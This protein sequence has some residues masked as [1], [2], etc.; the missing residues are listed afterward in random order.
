MKTSFV[1][2]PSNLQRPINGGCQCGYCKTHKYSTPLWDTL[3]FDDSGYSWAVHYPD[4]AQKT[5]DA[6][7]R[8]AS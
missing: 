3:A 5:A 8:K 4:F 6:I 1:R 2:L 7:R